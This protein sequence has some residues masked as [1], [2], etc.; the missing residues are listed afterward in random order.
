MARHRILLTLTATDLVWTAAYD[1]IGYDAV[2]GSL[3]TLRDTLGDFTAAVDSCVVND[4]TATTWPHG[5]APAAGAGFWYLVRAELGSGPLTYD[6]PGAGQVG[7]RD[8]EIDA[9]PNACP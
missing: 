4:T 5:A 8:A 7:S 2:R 6:T 3:T 1:A 9:S